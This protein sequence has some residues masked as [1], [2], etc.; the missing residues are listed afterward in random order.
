V[1]RTHSPS[2][3]LRTAST[4]RTGTPRASTVPTS[5]PARTRR[6]FATSSISPWTSTLCTRRGSLQV[7][8]TAVAATTEAAATSVSP[9]TRPTRAHV[10]PASRRSTTTTVPMVSEAPQ[11]FN[12]TK[13]VALVLCQSFSVLKS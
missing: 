6:S 12:K 4:G 5:S 7:A 9:A 1:C 13:L 10:Q 3:C 11:T 8:G 2:R